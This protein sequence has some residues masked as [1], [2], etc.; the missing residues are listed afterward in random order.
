MGGGDGS[1]ALPAI[2][3]PK[4]R[5]DMGWTPTTHSPLCSTLSRRQS[6]NPAEFL[7]PDYVANVVVAGSSPVSCSRFASPVA[8]LHE[9]PGGAFALLGARLHDPRLPAPGSSRGWPRGKS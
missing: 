3:P 1:L 8:D 6:P 9:F 5:V 2:G 4:A 7:D